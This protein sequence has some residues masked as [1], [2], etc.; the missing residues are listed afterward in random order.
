MKMMKTHLNNVF[1]LPLVAALGLILTGPA[2]AQ[3]F[4]TL[5]SF[6]DGIDGVSLQAG[7]VL[8]GNVLY[9][10]T[11][12]GGPSGN[13]STLFAVNTNGSGF[14]IVY[15][16]SAVAANNLGFNTNS[17]AGG[18]DGTLVLS[19]NTLYGASYEGGTNGTG[20]VFAV[21]TNGTFTLLHS[22]SA[23]K[24][25]PAT[26]LFTN[27]DGYG[28]EAGLILSGSTLYG[29]T[30]NGG[31]SGYGVV[32]KVNTNGTGFVNL[33]SFTNGSDGTTPEG[34]LLQS[35]ILY[36]VACG[37]NTTNA[38]VFKLNTNGTGFTTL[39][40]F[41]GLS[42][43][44]AL[45]G[46]TLYGIGGSPTNGGVFAIQ[47]DGTG[48]TNLYTFTATSGPLSTNSDGAQTIDNGGLVLSGNTLYGT[49]Y[50]GG[51]AGNGT[52]FAVNTNG[53]G[54][55]TLH[56]FTAE[57]S[58]T[59]NDG[60]NPYSGLVLSG[61]TL[62]GTAKKGGI[63]G[64]GT[65]FSISVTVNAPS[66]N[67]APTSI[68]GETIIFN[69]TQPDVAT[70]SQ[71]FSGLNFIDLGTNT[72]Y[73]IYAW[74]NVDSNDGQLTQTN[75]EPDSDYGDISTLMLTYTNVYSG[76]VTGVVVFAGGGSK[77]IS[78]T[79]TTI[80]LSPLMVTTTTLPNGTNGV[81]YSQTLT[82]SGGQ[83]PYTWTNI[84]G[85]LP[86]GLT[87]A[88]NGVISGTPTFAGDTNFAVRVT[89][90]N[91]NTATQTLS[92]NISVF[93]P[94]QVLAAALTNGTSGVAYSQQLTAAGGQPP[95]YNWSV[96]SGSLPPGLTLGSNG[97]I[98]GT[99]MLGGTASFT[100][101]VTDALSI[102]ATEPMTLTVMA[103]VL[104][105]F[106]GSPTDGANP[107]TVILSGNTLYGTASDG[108]SNGN[109]TVFA[110]NTDGTGFTNFYNFSAGIM[111][112]AP[113]PGGFY[114]VNSDGA[115]PSGELI[116][117][118]N[119]LYGTTSDEG[120]MD[121]GTVFEVNTDGTS[122]TNLHNFNGYDG[123]SPNCIILSGNTLY[124]TVISTLFT[125]KSDGTSLTNLYYF[126]GGD[127][128]VEL[129]A[130]L[131][132][133]GNTLYGTMA[134]NFMVVNSSYSICSV[135]AINT[136]G[137]GFR[138]LCSFT[139]GSVLG[140]PMSALTLAGNTLYGTVA[141]DDGTVFAVNTDGTGFRNLH[142]F[143]G[144]D[145][146]W[147]IAG[148]T[149]SDNT[150]YGTTI[151]G[152]N[153]TTDLGSG[154]V[155]A[156][157][158]DGTGYTSLYKFTGGSDGDA[159]WAG[160][161][162]TGSTLYG[163]TRYGGTN[164]NGTVF[165]LLLPPKP[166][167]VTTVALPN[168][169][170]GVSYT[171]QLSANYGQPPYSWS[172]ISGVI[173]SGLFLATNGAI[174][175]TPTNSGTNNF[176]V[177]VTDTSNDMATQALSL[178]VFGPPMVAIQPTNNSLTIPF[179]NNVTLSVSVTG[180]GPFS[181][182]WQLNG[183][184][185]PN[186]IITTVAGGYVGEGVTATNASLKTPV[187]LLKDKSG[188]LWIADTGHQLIRK[189]GTNGI[190]TTVA[191]NGNSGYSGDGG[192]A[193]NASFN[194]PA[195]LAMDAAGNLFIADGNNVV[196]RVDTNGIITTVAGGGPDYPGDGEAATN[197]SM[198]NLA[199]VT[200]DAAGNLFIAVM[201]NNVV[202][203]VD[204]H[205]VITT[206]AGN[207][208]N[209]YSGDGGAATN[210]S[211]NNPSGVAVDAVGN[212]FIADGNNYRVRVVDTNGNITTMAGGG[213]NYPGD[214]G[215]ATNAILGYPWGVSVDAARNVY[216]A[217][218]W[219]NIIR[220]V[221]AQGII[222]TLAGGGPD[223]PGDGEAATN[224]SLNN[225]EGVT[226]DAAGNLFI[227]DT[228]NNRIRQ[229][230][231]AGTINTVA[232]GYLGEGV[233]ATNASL[234]NPAG[235]A[236]DALGNLYISDSN[237]QRIRKVGINGI[238]TTVAGNGINNYAGDGGAATNAS[239]SY[240]SGV[241]VD[242]FGH[243]FI[244][245]AGNSA[246][247]QVDSQGLI[248]AMAGNGPDYP[249]DG[250]TA[251]N[252]ELN[253]PTG[254]AVDSAGDLFI[255]EYNGN[256]IRKVGING[257]ISTAAGN[258]NYGSS[259]DGGPATNASLA[260]PTAV[261]TDASGDLF[262]ADTGNSLVRKV[263][264][265]GIIW[266]VTGGGLDYPG[267]GE[268]ATNVSLNNPQGVTVDVFGNLFIADTVNNV[269]RRVDA[270]GFIT[271]VAG[272]YNYAYSG[273]GGP[274]TNASIANPLNVTTDASGNLFIADAGNNR[275]RKVVFQG[276]TLALNNV[277]FGNVGAYDVVVS[278]PYGSVT[279]S[280]VNI[281]VT[282]PVILSSPQIT[283]GNTNFTFQLSGPAGS[284]YVLQVSTNLLNWS[285]ASTSTIP[286]GG[287]VNLTNAISGYNNRF[288]R[289]HLQ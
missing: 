195:G 224:V 249:G 174:S 102:T 57:S 81:A 172:L 269:I 43:G 264:T 75:M 179:G 158:T 196:R 222:T 54:F 229:V 8:S 67:F 12:Y 32:F 76:T 189:L 217:D 166:L 106:S 145:G 192:P 259:G 256:R 252:V 218:S 71:M 184:N 231:A 182:Q 70:I 123:F 239:L 3:T 101:E 49:A 210:A 9:G 242:Q 275:V 128:A 200:V 282:L 183:T 176:T 244:A 25:N 168:G 204:T 147:P 220:R 94:L 150:L 24:T 221:D 19:G 59:N 140:E 38:A 56:S 266:T 215:V 197:V 131:I 33:H 100:V 263:D 286:V 191:G 219:N 226:V 156:I 88:T 241:A 16:F 103:K 250:E 65:V 83:M 48:F 205:G 41:P 144:S 73:G 120:T 280:V 124:G 253:G 68:S 289:V 268:A 44:M 247:R 134:Q 122:F 187:G 39:H 175:G 277:G 157:N 132:L 240:P 61:N 15:N 74:S 22:F 279:S 238:I 285:P 146:S 260:N 84:S 261:T 97:L 107:G 283:V 265:G 36:G 98:S 178:I 272:N 142:S 37:F 139:G 141:I 50:Y 287:T 28:S 5:H 276:P 95:Y 115:N 117:S 281:V 69:T 274:A 135:F 188:N 211:L 45:S 127:S 227:A 245:D 155:F 113:Y 89:D 105:T 199:G 254:V 126:T 148:L 10:T 40:S 80:T 193:T 234:D 228:G 243:L 153:S 164:G 273:D 62:Y 47:T 72:S 138:V 230:D 133:S 190:I 91:N 262:I 235:V 212:L 30:E 26:G 114:P 207:G 154:T 2:T 112:Q 186:G 46:N 66:T 169:T 130:G 23:A 110:V 52:V 213:T 216:I 288:Y 143:D 232:G 13:N 208:T 82:A 129:G 42:L 180:T 121:Y 136:D 96:A 177:K 271:T 92:L 55:A 99:P 18:S 78:G 214:G 185:L 278:G 258:G 198:W 162:L 255:A 6:T 64:A 233:A 225:P 93:S 284:N 29:T 1:L 165:S 246:I 109:G 4:T 79:F 85:A 151:A 202:R 27:S 35:N 149:L 206:V 181:Y 267:D 237:N 270:Q 60:A 51:S 63:G 104:H 173:P 159:P 116:L 53:S 170:N 160:L 90:A 58:G 251:T 20:T 21:N 171:N 11:E 125:M 201:W 203:R 152:G 87:L 194:N 209:G 31:T 248:T 17:D 223:F 111:V 77:T 108:G 7:L 137:T 34:L 236:L 14:R 86:P 257:I 163:T 167:Q 118:G 161:T 119:T